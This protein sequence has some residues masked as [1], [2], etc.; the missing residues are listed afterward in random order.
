MSVPSCVVA[1]REG[2]VHLRRG[3]RPLRYQGVHVLRYHV[4]HVR[5]AHLLTTESDARHD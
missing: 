5:R 2:M 4:L 3:L 1:P